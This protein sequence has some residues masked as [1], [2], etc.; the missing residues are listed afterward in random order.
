MSIGVSLVDEAFL[1]IRR[2]AANQK[3]Y[4]EATEKLLALCI[5]PQPLAIHTELFILVGCEPFEQARKTLKTLIMTSAKS[6]NQMSNSH[7]TTE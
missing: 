5:L 1:Y 6:T 7:A 2:L 3:K 4:E